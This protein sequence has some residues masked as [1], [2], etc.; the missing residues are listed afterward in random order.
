MKIPENKEWEKREEKS[1]VKY[2]RTVQNMQ[3][4]P[5]Q[6]QMITDIS[7]ILHTGQL[8]I[9]ESPTGTGKT[10][11]ALLAGIY[12]LNK[13][14]NES[15][16]GVS[17]ENLSI[18]TQLYN[19]QKN[20]VIYACRTHMQLNQVINELKYINKITNW[21]ISGIV[22][23]SRN[24][25]CINDRVKNSLGDI[26]NHCRLAV[27]ENK[28]TYY[29]QSQKQI[30]NIQ[31]NKSITVSIEE[32]IR[33]G[34]KEGTCP[35]YNTKRKLSDTNIIII[36]YLI[37]LD[38]QFFKKNTLKE[39]DCLVIIDEGHNLYEAV[40]ETYSS[41]VIVHEVLEVL[42][43]LSALTKT[44][45]NEQ[46]RID[47]L[48]IY[49]FIEKVYTTI[50]KYITSENREVPRISKDTTD[51]RDTKEDKIRM[52]VPVNKFVY[53]SDILDSNVFS[54][55]EKITKY[56]LSSRISPLQRENI[57]NRPEQCMRAIQKMCLAIGEC[58]RNGYLLVQRESVHF[59]SLNGSEHLSHLK[60][61]ANILVIG[62]TLYPSNTLQQLFNR[63][64]IEKK[65]PSLCTSIQVAINTS[66]H[67]VYS[68][69]EKEAVRVISLILTSFKMLLYGGILVFVQSKE[70]LGLIVS[71]IAKQKEEYKAKYSANKC[72]SAIF[73]SD[74]YT[75]YHILNNIMFE[76]MTSFKEYSQYIQ[77]NKKGIMIC[78]MGGTLSEGVNF[79]DDLCRV[80]IICGIPLPT[81][82]KEV[83]FLV[84]HRGKEYFIQKA[85]QLINQTIGRAVRHKSDYCY[86]SLLDKRF[87]LYKN[88]LSSW[89]HP[90]ITTCS[91]PGNICDSDLS[92]ILSKWKQ[93]QM[94]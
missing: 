51:I 25:T 23:G 69:R 90:Y 74:A 15:I 3:L 67:F 14:T 83:E 39:K 70:M 54:I 92:S 30:E 66:Y 91:N 73:D 44:I 85:F 26:N 52:I 20:S 38:K 48:E 45:S 17:E 31:C 35:Y 84:R 43:L 32:S 27:K 76:G 24:V 8:G 57:N 64:T 19:I 77:Q 58:D 50:R 87:L 63:A 13:N 16:T 68:T 42:N 10:L 94:Q 55:A 29:I 9:L 89:I 75:C 81:P 37:L 71:V 22:A 80:L 12:F 28:C 49:I 79:T 47:L 5:G 41:T 78:V 36:P 65:Y 40:L 62:G 56:H 46:Q 6:I 53:D 11:S 86:V 59:K 33:I 18:L 72:K 7:E 93:K 60:E 4:Y 21:N 2:L 1:V 61:V 88:Y 34:K 82:S